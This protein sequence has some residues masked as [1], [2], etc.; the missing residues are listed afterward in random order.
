MAKEHY[1]SFCQYINSIK[2]VIAKIPS[3]HEK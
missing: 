3:S 1:G 2:E